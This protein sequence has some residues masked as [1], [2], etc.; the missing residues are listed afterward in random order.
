MFAYICYFY[1]EF[2]NNRYEVVINSQFRFSTR[3]CAKKNKLSIN[4][5][6][7]YLPGSSTTFLAAAGL[8]QGAPLVTARD[9]LG[10]PTATKLTRARNALFGDNREIS[11]CCG[12]Q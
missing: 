8:Y 4:K 3:D 12:C 5:Q 10:I 2:M 11:L 1:L 6:Q 7:Y 9:V